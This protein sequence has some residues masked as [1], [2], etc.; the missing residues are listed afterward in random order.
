VDH[1]PPYPHRVEDHRPPIPI[2]GDPTQQHE[3]QMTT[4]TAHMTHNSEDGLLA[5]AK[6]ETIYPH[7]AS[8]TAKLETI[9]LHLAPATAKPSQLSA[10][11]PAATAK[12]E[13]IYPQKPVTTAK[14]ETIWHTPPAAAAPPAPIHHPL[15]LKHFAVHN[16]LATRL[17]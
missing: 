9:S 14:S 17:Q 15:R 1:R 8:T 3:A 13:T 7:L 16:P 5:T 2:V 11:R 12:P 4:Q 6:P 10:H